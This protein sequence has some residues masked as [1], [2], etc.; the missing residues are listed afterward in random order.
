M[1]Y[2]L[3]CVVCFKVQGTTRKMFVANDVDVTLTNHRV[4]M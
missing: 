1:H 3:N 4:F 2:I